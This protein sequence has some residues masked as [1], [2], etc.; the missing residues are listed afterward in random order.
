MYNA[1]P[2]HL[3]YYW[4]PTNYVV[5]RRAGFAF[6]LWQNSRTMAQIRPGETLWAFTRNAD[7][8]YVLAAKVIAQDVTDQNPDPRYGRYRVRGLPTSRLFDVDDAPDAE[9]L[10]RS[11]S[12]RADAPALGQSFQGA[13][14]VRPLTDDDHAR[15]SEFAR[16]MADVVGIKS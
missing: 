15:L 10:I 6:A 7:G 14:A 11:L 9:P 12:I 13:S 3:L 4:K 1:P 2:M 8:R 16:S 5:D